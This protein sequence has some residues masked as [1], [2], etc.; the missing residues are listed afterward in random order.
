MRD[1]APIRSDECFDEARVAAYLREHLPGLVGD[2]EIVFDQFPGGK[3]NLTYQATAGDMALVLRRP[4]LGPL[5]PGSHDMRRE[6]R[7]LSVLHRAYRPAPEAFHLCEDESIMGSVFLVMER[8]RGAVIRESWPADLPDDDRFR[9]RLA[10]NAVDTLADL[11]LVDYRALGLDD[12]GRPDGFVERQVAGWSDRWRKARED[13]VPAMDLLAE[14]LA[15]AVPDPQRATLLH[16]D[17]KIDNV[18]AGPGAEVV[19]VLDWDMSTIGDPL[20]DLGTALAYWSGPD[21]PTY[22]VFGSQGYTLAHVMGKPEIAERYAA[23]TG[24]D[25]S[26]LAFYEALA[27]F[28]IAVIVQQIYIRWRRG[29]TS[30]D[31]FAVLGAMVPPVAESGLEL[32]GA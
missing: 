10:V 7:V 13:D 17:F 6:Y 1:T 21:D 31:R 25:I 4:P 5:A 15:G 27:L 26:G 23:R 12:L 9:R 24:F 20:V 8:R 18:M 3:A 32:L 22:P 11:H 28:R 2:T 19:A 16:N 29:Q 30:D 14:G